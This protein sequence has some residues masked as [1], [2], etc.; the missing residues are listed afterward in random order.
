MYRSGDHVEEH[1][2]ALNAL[3]DA[4]HIVDRDIKI[5]WMNDAYATLLTRLGLPSDIV[6]KTVREA[7]PFLPQIIF[8]EYD[9]SLAGELVV[10]TEVTVMP[11]G[12]EVTTETNKI[13]IVSDDMVVGVVTVIRDLTEQNRR[14][15]RLLEREARFR[16]FMENIELIAVS[17]DTNGDIIFCNDHALR[18]CGWTWDEV[19]G[20]NW[21]ELFLPSDVVR[22]TVEDYHASLMSDG[23]DVPAHLDNQIVTK[24]GRILDISWSNT[25]LRD[26]GG[27]VVGTA[28]IGEDITERRAMERRLVE[29]AEEQKC[30][31]EQLRASNQKLS[32]Y[33]QVVSHDLRRPLRTAVHRIIVLKDSLVSLPEDEVGRKLDEVVEVLDVARSLTDDLL[34]YAEI[35]NHG[36]ELSAVALG[37]IVDQVLST[38]TEAK[39]SRSEDMP[40]VLGDV[41]LVRQVL[42]NLLD[43]SLKFNVAERK[44]VS[45]VH[46]GTVEGMTQ[47]DVVDNGTGIPT[48]WR[49]EVFRPFSK[50]GLAA[51]SGVGLAIVKQSMERMG[52]TV[53]FTS[54]EGRGTIFHLK[55]RRSDDEHVA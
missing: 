28:S 31:S 9:R 39:L 49:E 45:V 16:K 3:V 21:F 27:E 51:G 42:M 34:T 43:N 44:E 53:D 52:G 17:L 46:R 33:S 32:E 11:D 38:V 30:L 20:K 35:G 22:E 26:D 18:L 54:D 7:S 2:D 29:V 23:E 50:F 12:A 40:D 41:T 4:I 13:P 47:I 25:I 10:T 8:D 36:M 5:T 24:D 14:F 6:G 48:Q 55:F 15:A 19:R 1:H 37:P